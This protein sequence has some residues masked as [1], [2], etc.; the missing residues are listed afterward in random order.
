[1][2]SH[3]EE[4]FIVHLD[5]DGIPFAVDFFVSPVPHNGACPKTKNLA[6]NLAFPSFANTTISIRHPSSPPP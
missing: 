5:T 2:L 3:T 1:M 6:E 4:H